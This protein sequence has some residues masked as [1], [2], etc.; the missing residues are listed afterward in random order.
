MQSDCDKLQYNKHPQTRHT[1]PG[2]LSAP[3]PCSGWSIS[4]S[5]VNTTCI[6]SCS[7]RQ[8]TAV[9]QVDSNRAWSERAFQLTL[10]LS[11]VV[12]VVTFSWAASSSRRNLRIW[13]LTRN[14]ITISYDTTCNCL[15][16]C[17]VTSSQFSLPQ[18][19]EIKALHCCKA[20]AKINRKMGNSILPL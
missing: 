14:N 3:A 20:H 12:N 1:S 5:V 7:D 9:R 19:M 13:A 4:R 10:V 11:W 15:I 17:D 8:Q 18:D 6:I 2:R 16:T